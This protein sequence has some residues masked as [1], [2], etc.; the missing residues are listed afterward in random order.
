MAGCAVLLNTAAAKPLVET[1][2]GFVGGFEE[3]SVRRFLGIP[4]AA[5][6]VGDLR[7]KPP[8]PHSIWSGVLDAEQ[9]G[10]HCAQIAHVVGES[11]NSEDCLFLNVYVPNE[12]DGGHDARVQRSTDL[13]ARAVMVWIHGGAFTAGKATISTRADL[14][15]WEA[16][17]SSR[18]IIVLVYSDFWRIRH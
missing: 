6:P 11:S 14:P 4:Y 16:S 18:S 9:F 12:P 10:S 2:Q 7:W 13:P 3:A 8:Q 5:P 17:S 15:K 1:M